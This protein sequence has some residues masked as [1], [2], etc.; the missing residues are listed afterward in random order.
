MRTILYERHVELGAKMVPFG[1]FEMPLSYEGVVAE[2]QAVRK[3]CGLFDVSHMGLVE[4]KGRDAEPFLEFVT[5]G[6]IKGRKVGSAI[7]TVMC[8]EK[9]GSVDDLMVYKLGQSHF[10]LV[11]NASNRHKDL[12]HLQFY[13]SNYSVEVQPLF[14]QWVI[15]ALQGPKSGEI[16]R[17]DI[18]KEHTGHFVGDLFIAATGYTGEKGFELYVPKRKGLEVFNALLN[19][20]S[21]PCG[22]GAR[23]TLRLEMGYA[24]Y[25]HELND[26]RSPLESVAAWAV[27]MDKDFLGRRAIKGPI[28]RAVA[29]IVEEGIAREGDRLFQNNVDVGMVTSG[30]FS[31]T[32]KVGIALGLVHGAGPFEVLIRGKRVKVREV[33]LPF[34]GNEER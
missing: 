10:W 9:G 19:S 2:H 17:Y 7:Y 27:K 18:P 8:N 26:E 6:H 29:L 24:L 5:T 16:L 31:P 28:Q 33:D 32:L 1:G 14:D 30:N 25:G 23:D 20:G 13:A 4:V 11:V 3:G 34:I 15:L 22:L 12:K 21:K